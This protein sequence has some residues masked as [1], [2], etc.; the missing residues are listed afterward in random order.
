MKVRKVCFISGLCILLFIFIFIFLGQYKLIGIKSSSG[1]LIG[2]WSRGQ[3]ILN[4]DIDIILKKFGTNFSEKQKRFKISFVDKS[5]T[6]IKFSESGIYYKCLN[7]VK[8]N[9]INIY[10]EKDKIKNKNMASNL[11]LI[12]LKCSLV[13]IDRGSNSYFDL[14]N[15]LMRVSSDKNI[16]KSL[17]IPLGK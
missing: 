10:V 14:M 9:R 13:E 8:Y 15:H 2:L 12:L 5:Q 7:E 4:K 17:Y 16:I 1:K 11:Y 3:F 6:D